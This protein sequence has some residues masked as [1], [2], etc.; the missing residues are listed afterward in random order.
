MEAGAGSVSQRPSI[1]ANF[2][3]L[4]LSDEVTGFIA[5]LSGEDGGDQAEDSGDAEAA[6]SK[7]HIAALEHVPGRN[8][9]NKRGASAVTGG[10]GMEEI[11]PVPMG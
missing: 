5:L 7:I 10:D 4:I 2:C 1:A 9:Q 3:R 6:L 11:W 8:R